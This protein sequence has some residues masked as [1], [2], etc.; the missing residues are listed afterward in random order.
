MKPI[1]CILTHS[2]CYRGTTRGRPV[3]VL[4]HD[5]GAGNPWLKRYVQPWE[6]EAN[7]DSLIA[8]LG[9]NRYGNDW[10]HVEIQKGVNAFIGKLADG[11]VATVQTLGWLQRPWGCGTGRYG[12]CNGSPEVERSPF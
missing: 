2:T 7:Y 5:T 4:W 11:S 1:T 6:G 8:L 9:K 10:N 3:G 12:S